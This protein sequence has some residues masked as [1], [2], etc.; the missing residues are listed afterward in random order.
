[1]RTPPARGALDSDTF[2]RLGRRSCAEKDNVASAPDQAP[3]GWKRL[4]DVASNVVRE[5]AK[6]HGFEV[7]PD[8]RE[9]A[10]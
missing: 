3:D 5:L 4:G 6:R 7:P 8:L 1:M 9:A 10:E 2:R